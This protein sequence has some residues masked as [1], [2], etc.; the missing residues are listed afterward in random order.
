MSETKTKITTKNNK[1]L[2]KIALII[3]FILIIIIILKLSLS[4]NNKKYSKTQ[5]ILNNN[6]ITA[7][8]KDDIIL[9]DKKIYMSFEDIK[10]TLD[11]TIYQ[12]EETNLIITSSEYKVASLNPDNKETITINGA[13]QEGKDSVIN[14]N[15]KT[16][17]NISDLESVY[18]CEIKYIETTNIV[19]IDNLNKKLVKA[20]VKN[21]VKV[22]EKNKLFSKTIEKLKKDDEVIY[23]CDEEEKAKIRTKNGNIGY[24]NKK[25]LDNF[26]NEREDFE[27]INT[28]TSE[29]QLEYDITG[30]DLT[31]FKKREEVINLIL[32]EAIEN[33][34]M[35][36]KVLYN[37][38]KDFY[39][40]RFKI[41]VIAI[42][43]E[44][45]ITIDI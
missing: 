7:E 24:I 37:G 31:S 30:K 28:K 35:Y 3:V 34:N 45:G 10:N 18:N 9:K 20:T 38:E 14:E 26:I 4:V 40:E 43:K 44:C 13:N 17:I 1:G 36:V 5:I 42:L 12:E 11:T 22:K 19:T 29:K 39:F 15:E 33:D 25:S 21:N 8:L 6:N 16:Y 27:N 32:Q 23:I 41:E 2:N